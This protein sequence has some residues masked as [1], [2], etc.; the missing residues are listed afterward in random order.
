M[1]SQ[2]YLFY[3]D[4]EL[5]IRERIKELKKEISDSMNIEQ[6]DAE[7]AQL[8]EI[9]SALRTQPLLFGEKLTIIKNADLRLELWDT[10][11]PA[12]D[13][14]PPATTVVFWASSVSKRSKIFKRIDA[15][16]EVYEFK[17]FADWEQEKVAYW[18]MQRVKSR[19]KV[20][21]RDVALRLIDIC[22]NNLGKVSSEIEKI[23]TYIGD[24]NQVCSKDVE[25]LASPGQISI[26]SL[27]DAVANKNLKKAL[28]SFRLLQKNKIEF[29]SV[30]SLLANRYRIMLL[31]KS[32]RD[33]MVISKVLKANPYYVKKCLRSEA[34]FSEKELTQNLQLILEADLNLKSGQS[35]SSVFELLLTSLCG[36]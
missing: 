5:L 21:S 23:I 32:E 9:I 15:L 27:S 8:E 31:G 33:P 25:A 34:A 19:G 36:K 13:S 4:E 17:S 10:V 14:I 16:G 11:V 3:G 20:I 1:A 6:I 2:I 26:F 22:G 7:A 35:Q 12:L 30:L 28:E 29:F 24:N 18:V